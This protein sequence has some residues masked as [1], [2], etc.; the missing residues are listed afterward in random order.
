V[1]EGGACDNNTIRE[2]TIA[3][4]RG[5]GV[6]IFDGIFSGQ[7]LGNRVLD[8]T[9]ADNQAHGIYIFGGENNRL[10]GNHITGTPTA[11]TTASMRRARTI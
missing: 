6:T 11:T 4:N 1:T 9:I 5:S 8:C 2:C 3:G 10:E 7:C